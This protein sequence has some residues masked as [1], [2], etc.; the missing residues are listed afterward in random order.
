MINS[1]EPKPQGEAIPGLSQ[2]LQMV[3][4]YINAR[5][6]DTEFTIGYKERDKQRIEAEPAEAELDIEE[7][8]E[9][10]GLDRR[11]REAWKE[12]HLSPDFLQ[13]Q[14]DDLKKQRAHRVS[15][16]EGLKKGEFEECVA[17]LRNRLNA[18]EQSEQLTT[19]GMTSPQ[20]KE[21]HHAETRV[22]RQYIA[23]LES[24]R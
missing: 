16:L 8:A 18:M 4:Q 22:L 10:L 21:K 2:D 6:K 3:G 20:Y 23:L 17:Y 5:I 14:I 7:E 12:Q 11:G 13:E 19:F 1:S 15:L 24:K 9:A